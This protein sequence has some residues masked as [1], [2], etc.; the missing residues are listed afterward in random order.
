MAIAVTSDSE[1]NS[2][3][4]A[5]GSPPWT[6][7]NKYTSMNERIKNS[8]E[9]DRLVESWTI[10][11]PPES[12]EEILQKAGVGAGVVANAQD[13][14]E[15]PQLNY[16]NYYREFDHPYMGRLRYYHPAGI[17]LSAAETATARPV[18]LGEHNEKI[19]TGI[20]GMSRAE[21]E[22]LKQKGIFE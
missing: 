8:D 11:Y 4:K 2:F 3:V 17:K 19:C 1:W 18:L 20:L 10:N 21:F 15:D 22:S 16:Y 9:L 14:D 6:G 13:M 7:A 5:I 12:V